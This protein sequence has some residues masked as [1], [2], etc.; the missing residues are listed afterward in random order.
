MFVLFLAKNRRNESNGWIQFQ[1]EYWTNIFAIVQFICLRFC[2][3]Q[4]SDETLTEQ[5]E[6]KQKE[7]VFFSLLFLHK[8]NRKEKEWK[9]NKKNKRIIKIDKQFVLKYE[10]HKSMKQWKTSQTDS[11]TWN[12]SQQQYA[13]LS[14]RLSTL[15]SASVNLQCNEWGNELTSI[16]DGKKKL[17]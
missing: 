13:N 8:G 17:R 10:N 5:N 2:V 3:Q 9:A 16:R 14:I 15:C 12:K 4:K 7:K 6:S 11:V 1:C